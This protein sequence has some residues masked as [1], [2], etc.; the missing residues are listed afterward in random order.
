M[1]NSKSQPVAETSPTELQAAP[2]G[3]ILQQTPDKGTTKAAPPVIQLPADATTAQAAPTPTPKSMKIYDKLGGKEAIQAAVDIFYG[4]ILADDSINGFFK[5]TDMKEQRS[6]QML[7]MCYAL[8]GPQAWKGKNMYEAHKGLN[9]K[10]EHFNAVAGHFIATLKELNVPQD[11]IDEAVAVV[12]STK[13]QVLGLEN[14]DGPVEQA[15]CPFK[16]E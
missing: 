3:E 13:N 12:A 9:L 6:K 7:F 14:P 11:V 2:T 1:G 8:G 10:E 16:H 15:K 4:K 5:N